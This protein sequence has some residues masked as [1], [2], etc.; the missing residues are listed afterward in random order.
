[1]TVQILKTGPWDMNAGCVLV[2]L[3][4]GQLLSEVF[5]SELLEGFDL[6]KVNT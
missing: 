2:T 3:V 5:S 6:F 4:G 1:M